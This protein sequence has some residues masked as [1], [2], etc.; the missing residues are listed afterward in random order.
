MQAE[1]KYKILGEQGETLYEAKESSEF[2]QRLCYANVRH[3]D[4]AIKDTTNREVISL[5]RPLNCAGCCCACLYPYFTQM[6]EVAMGGRVVG[7]CMGDQISC[8]ID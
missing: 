4:L 1:K 6:M 2:C 3:L 5:R 7:E 8:S